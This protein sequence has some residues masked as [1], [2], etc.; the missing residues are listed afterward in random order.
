MTVSPHRPTV[1]ACVHTTE[2]GSVSSWGE[3]VE[4]SLAIY[5]CDFWHFI[6]ERE[7][8]IGFD[9]R[10]TLSR[11]D[12][13]K[14]SCFALAALATTPSVLRVDY[15]AEFHRGL[16]PIVWVR[17]DAPRDRSHSLCSF[18]KL[19]RCPRRRHARYIYLTDYSP[20]HRVKRQLTAEVQHAQ[21]SIDQHYG[22]NILGGCRRGC[23][24]DMDRCQRGA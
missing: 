22:C 24:D 12:R 8:S 4:S 20:W 6:A 11:V 3:Q 7:G 2:F 23:H 18:E 9:F 14:R 13:Q 17:R 10:E 21:Y 15:L 19:R 1:H 5:P 16:I